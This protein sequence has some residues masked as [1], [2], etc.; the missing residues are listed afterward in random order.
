MK[1]IEELG[2]LVLGEPVPPPPELPADTI[3]EQ[4]K[5]RRGALIPFVAGILGRMNGPAAA[6]TLGR[7][8][9]LNR[10]ARLTPSLLAHELVHVEQWDRDRL[11]PLRYAAASLRHGYWDN[12]YEVEA[13]AAQNS[14]RTASSTEDTA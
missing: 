9:I 10:S 1:V 3:P 7:T 5:L 11:F 13:R 2:R 6:V 14:P 4:V 8:I 12:P